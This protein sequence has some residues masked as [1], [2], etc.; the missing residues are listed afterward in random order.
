[1]VNPAATLQDMVQKY[2]DFFNAKNMEGLSNLIAPN[3]SASY[4]FDLNGTLGNFQEVKGKKEYLST[5]S[6]VAQS[7]ERT[8]KRTFVFQVSQKSPCHRSSVL[9]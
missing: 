8:I 1:M 6:E 5:V 2:W 3:F 4:A 7:I 9:S